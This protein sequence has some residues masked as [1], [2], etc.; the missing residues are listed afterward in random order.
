MQNK[1]LK[2]V[3][4]IFIIMLFGF[5]INV[6]A[7]EDELN[8]DDVVVGGQN[9]EEDEPTTT[10]EEQNED[11]DEDTNVSHD[12]DVGSTGSSRNDSSNETKDEVTSSTYTPPSQ[13]LQP[14]SSYSTSATIPE[15]NLSLN[16]ILNVILIAIGVI[17]ILLAIAI[18]I[19]LK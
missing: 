1:Y 12:E 18:F 11:V 3:L 7:T 6:M 10:S 16:N 2:L 15:A 17:L 9:S 14:T 19:R 13:T 5:T 4:T 8:S